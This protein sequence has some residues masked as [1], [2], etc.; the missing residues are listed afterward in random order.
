MRREAVDSERHADETWGWISNVSLSKSS[1]KV[2]VTAAR[3][4]LESVLSQ[5]VGVA[6]MQQDL[7]NLINHVGDTRTSDSPAIHAQHRTDK[8]KAPRR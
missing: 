6:P 7:Q 5:Q 8:R 4:T 2:S 3:R 1:R